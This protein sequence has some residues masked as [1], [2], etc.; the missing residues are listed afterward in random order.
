MIHRYL[1]EM[2]SVAGASLTIGAL[3]EQHPIFPDWLSNRED[4][5]SYFAEWE[6]FKVIPSTKDHV[7]CLIFEYRALRRCKLLNKRWN[8]GQ[9]SETLESQWFVS[10]LTMLSSE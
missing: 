1:Y 7:F 4:F 10:Y 8:R 5:Q 9:K 3:L 6:E 2:Q